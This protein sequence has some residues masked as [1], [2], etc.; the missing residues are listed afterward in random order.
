MKFMK[1]SKILDSSNICKKRHFSR[2]VVKV[3]R[4]VKVKT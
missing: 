2:N 1:I 4:V 3:K